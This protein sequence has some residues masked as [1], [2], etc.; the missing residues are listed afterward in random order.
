MLN[1]QARNSAKTLAKL[2]KKRL[3]KRCK[4]YDAPRLLRG[5]DISPSWNM[6]ILDYTTKVPVA[7]T[8]G[9]GRRLFG[10]ALWVRART[11]KEPNFGTFCRSW[12]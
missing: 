11:Q 3:V 4:N 10:L 5:K 2:L 9:Q 6:P 7:R 12:R 1:E 8:V